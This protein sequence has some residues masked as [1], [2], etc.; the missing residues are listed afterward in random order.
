[1]KKIILTIILFLFANVV[2][3]YEIPKDFDMDEFLDRPY[4]VTSFESALNQQKPF[5]L[6]F[7]NSKYVNSLFKFI[8]IAEMVDKEFGQNFNF[9]II[10]TKKPENEELVSY[11]KP[12]GL[13]SPSLYI[14]DTKKNKFLYVEKKYYNS[15]ALKKI[16]RKYLNGD[17][18]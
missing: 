17:L 12:S 7:A 10:N 16:L 2:F 18:F 6:V 5:L 14:V 15:I 11:F 4:Y 13:R 8:P 9:C 1:M 3:A